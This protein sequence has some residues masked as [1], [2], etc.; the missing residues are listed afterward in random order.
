MLSCFC[1]SWSV[2]ITVSENSSTAFFPQEWMSQNVLLVSLKP[3]PKGLVKAFVRLKWC[4]WVQGAVSM[5]RIPQRTIF[6]WVTDVV[7]LRQGSFMAWRAKWKKWIFHSSHSFLFICLVNVSNCIF[8]SKFRYVFVDEGVFFKA[9][10][11]CTNRETS[12]SDIYNMVVFISWLDAANGFMSFLIQVIW[13]PVSSTHCC[14]N[15]LAYVC[16][17]AVICVWVCVG[18]EGK[19]GKVVDIRGWDNESGRSVASVTWSNGTTNV[20]RMGHKGKVDLKY[21]SDGQGGF[22]Y[23][24]HLPK[25]GRLFSLNLVCR[26]YNLNINHCC[27]IVLFVLNCW[28]VCHES[29]LICHLFLG[30]HAELQRQESADGHSF[31]QGDKV[32]CLLEVDILRQM[33][34]G[35][36]GWNP[37]MAEVLRVNPA[38]IVIGTIDLH[39]LHSSLLTFSNFIDF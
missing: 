36:G 2:V 37:K 13:N 32:K 11:D 4:K 22:Y 29:F 20:Y 6:F 3:V 39:H 8:K 25:L 21:V 12:V 35:H 18:G 31:Q 19:V 9:L 30:E 1:A 38:H 17:S 34:E 28:L 14:I 26:V 15:V 16:F 33:Q 27:E 5:L 7:V 24:D 10:I 23:K